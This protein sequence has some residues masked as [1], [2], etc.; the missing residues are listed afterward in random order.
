DPE[1]TR[2]KEEARQEGLCSIAWIPLKAQGK[3]VGI[4]NVSTS[5]PRPFE[6]REVELLQ[7]IGSVIGVALENAQL[8]EGSRRQEEIQRLLKE[9]SQDITSFDIDSLVKK[10]TEK[11]RGF[12]K[13][14]VSD[15]RVVENGVW[16]PVGVSGIEPER[17]RGTGTNRG[18]STW[19]LE[20]RRPL[21]IA[22]ITKETDI[23]GGET[24]SRIGIRGLLAVPLFSRGGEVIGVLRA[25]TYQPR[26]FSQGEIDL[27]QQL[28]NGADIALEN[29][30]LYEETERNLE[31]IQDLYEIGQAA[32]STLDLHDVLNVLLDKI[33]FF[34]P[35]SVTTLRL[36]NKETGLLEA[37]AARN[38]DEKEWKAT[39]REGGRGFSKGALENKGPVVIGNV[40][41]NT[42][43]KY[44]EFLRK[45]G[46]ISYLGLPLVVKDNILG[47]L[48]FYT[49]EEHQFTSE[50]IQF[51]STL[52]GQAAI[53]IHNSQL[54]EQVDRKTRDISAL[55]GLTSTASQSLELDTVLQEVIKKFAEIFHFD[56]TRIFLFNAQMDELSLRASSEDQPES[57]AQTKP[58][59]RGQGIN[60]RVAESGELMIFE[61]L[62]S[63]PRYEE[64]TRVKLAKRAGFSFF[65]VFPIKS[66]QRTVGTIDCFGRMPRHLISDEIRLITS[67][68]HQIGI[69]V[70]NARLYAQ[71]KEQATQ[72]EKDIIEQKQAEEEL[73]RS[74]EQLRHLARHLQSVRETE[75]SS[76]AREI[77]DELGQV[78]SGLKMDLSW[79]RR[80]LSKDQHSLLVKTKSMLD[81]ID[82]TIQTVRKISTE[83]R[84]GALDEL[85]LTAAI[86]WQFQEFQNRTGIKGA[87]SSHLEE[88]HS[89]QA[90]STAVFRIFQEALT[91][92]ARHAKATRVNISLQEEGGS[93]ILQVTD[94]GRGIK[95]SKI[96]DGK[97]LG[98]LGMRERALPLG[99]EV[100]ISGRR[101]EGTTVTVRIPLN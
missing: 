36:I 44:P 72:L 11:V 92:I 64:L 18:R 78:L 2:L 50:E 87:V 58:F 56:M 98:L 20:N 21:A 55:Y 40:Q 22:D 97:S 38:V 82:Q 4:L 74:R 73:K 9:L 1:G 61:D 52:A 16:R 85:G 77:Q 25:L 51:L 39:M 43:A 26:E 46:L 15:I 27:M 37:V 88:I 48:G 28:A 59:R 75:R 32:T 84:P 93:M 53:A 90:R 89:D 33:D 45:Y 10:L 62:T 86:E 24:A 80:K 79:L 14:D 96:F 70:E 42:Q 6:P 71:T 34:L 7:A 99:G 66:K 41:K 95:E 13:V 30:R 54:Y 69:A 12:F 67:M 91:N 8:Y 100:A 29:A 23:P 31:R 63:D 83:L 17:I 19:I 60:G 76:I 101:G 47:T 49:K 65:A 5:Q 68:T 94:N 35:Y 81:L 57:F 3:V